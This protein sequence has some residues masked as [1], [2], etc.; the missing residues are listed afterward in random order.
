M[1]PSVF[2]SYSHDSKNHKTWVLQLATRLRHNG[3]NAILDQWNLSLG[4]DVAEFIERGLSESDR[5][6]CICSENYVRKATSTEGGVGYEKQIMTA[7]IM[8]DL[9]ADYV[10]PVIRD[11]TNT[12]L[13]PT[14]TFLMGRF[15][16]DFRDDLRYEEKYEELLRSL[17]DEPILPVPPIG[18]NP[19]ETIKQFSNQRFMPSSE[20]Y[21]SSSPKGHVTFDYI[22]FAPSLQVGS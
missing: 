16:V 21:V 1:A 18:D 12:D 3:V 17:L 9:G 15:Y 20:K 2:V 7:K 22:W 8:A 11:N 10:I 6:L 5:V 14:P 4:K 19:F 13:A